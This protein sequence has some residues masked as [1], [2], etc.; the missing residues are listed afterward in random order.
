MSNFIVQFDAPSGTRTILRESENTKRTKF[1]T[2]KK[3]AK[4]EDSAKKTEKKP[5]D[6]AKKTDEK[7]VVQIDVA[8]KT[9][10][11]P[12]DSTKKTEEVEKQ[13][14]KSIDAS[15]AEKAAA[16]AIDGVSVDVTKET[17]EKEK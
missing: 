13:P 16:P 17:D 4:P 12:E 6:S 10:K 1:P 15:V 9:E 5:E 14:V 8:K 3:A 11:K 2:Q 7:E